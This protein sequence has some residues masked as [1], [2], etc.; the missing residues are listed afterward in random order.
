[1]KNFSALAVLNIWIKK[2]VVKV[3]AKTLNVLTDWKIL[4]EP[5]QPQEAIKEFEKLTNK[6]YPGP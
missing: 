6:M 3:D 4:E 2:D 1:V 5:V